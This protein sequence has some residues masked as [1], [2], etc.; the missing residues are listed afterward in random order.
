VTSHRGRYFTLRRNPNGSTTESCRD[1]PWTFTYRGQP[2]P[3]QRTA[4]A[5]H[6][7]D[8]QAPAEAEQLTD[9]EEAT[10]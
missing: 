7:C 10:P 8:D 1:C 5:N 3:P 2:T 6:V 9:A 4:K